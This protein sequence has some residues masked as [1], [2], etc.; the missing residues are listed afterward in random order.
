MASTKVS[1]NASMGYR[2]DSVR[3]GGACGFG[4]A[5]SGPIAWQR[6]QYC[7]TS[8]R[9]RSTLSC[10]KAPVVSYLL[11]P[12]PRPTAYKNLA[13]FQRLMC[14]SVAVS[15]RFYPRLSSESNP[16]H[17]TSETPIRMALRLTPYRWQMRSR[18]GGAGVDPTVQAEVSYLVELT[19]AMDDHGTDAGQSALN[20]ASSWCDPIVTATGH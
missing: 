8:V 12:L 15:S 18:R 5:P 16:Q 1:S 4:L 19:L 9:P 17:R 3:N 13:I 20:P 6:L 2:S 14:G 7:V 11:Q 10:A